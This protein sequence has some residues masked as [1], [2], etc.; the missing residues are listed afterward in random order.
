MWSLRTR[1]RRPFHQNLQAGQQRARRS[2]SSVDPFRRFRTGIE[3]DG[4][5]GEVLL[6][7]AD[8]IRLHELFDVFRRSMFEH[9]AGVVEHQADLLAHES[10]VFFC[11]E[12]ER[13]VFESVAGKLHTCYNSTDMQF[14][15][16]KEWLERM[17]AAED[18][19][20]ITV[21]SPRFRAFMEATGPY[22]VHIAGTTRLVTDDARYEKFEKAVAHARAL[23]GWNIKT[24][25]RDE[26]TG[27]I[28][29]EVQPYNQD[30]WAKYQRENGLVPETSCESS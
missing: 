10:R 12:I 16:S 5:N 17:A 18:E 30:M 3:R 4:L 13:P 26:P 29:H 27:N 23:S 28:I 24:E 11:A 2:Q 21:I 19:G 6:H 14:T 1:G 22:T 20:D 9:C 25:I 8:L 7:L 15:Q